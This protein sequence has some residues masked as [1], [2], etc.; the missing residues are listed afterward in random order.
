MILYFIIGI[1]SW[2]LYGLLGIILVAKN[3][4]DSPSGLEVVLIV[5]LAPLL[6]T[7]FIIISLWGNTLILWDKFESWILR[8]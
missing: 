7:L 6:T 8:E 5:T 1:L 4:Y 3:S 2:V